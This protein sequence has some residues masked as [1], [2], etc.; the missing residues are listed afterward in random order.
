MATMRFLWL[1]V[2]LIFVH[3]LRAEETFDWLTRT[4]ATSAPTT[5]PAGRAGQSPFISPLANESLPAAITLSDGLR[6]TGRL[7]TTP[8]KP[9]RVWVEDRHQYIDLNISAIASISAAILWEREEPEWHFIAS[10]SD[11][12]EYTG[13][14]YPVRE[15]QYTFKLLDGQSITGGVVAPLYLKTDENADP[16]LFVLQKRSKGTVGQ[17]LSDLIFIRQ[18]DFTS[19]PKP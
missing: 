9:L 19:T 6:L 3:D 18:I 4:H 1:L 8:D 10:G 7:S 11:V 13:K 16:K 2:A 12:K 15:L 17:K 5:E 14:T